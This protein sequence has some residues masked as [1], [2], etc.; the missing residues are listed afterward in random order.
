MPDTSPVD[1]STPRS[2]TLFAAEPRIGVLEASRRL[3]L[4]RGTVQAR[5]DK[6][7]ARGVVTGWGPDVDAAALGFPVT[8]FVTLEIAQSG[9]DEIGAR[10]AAIPEVLEVHTITGGGDLL[11]AWWPAPTPTCSA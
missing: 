1:R 11:S 2:W 5:L 10:L 3:R 6:L 8:A 7:A 4:A 9:H